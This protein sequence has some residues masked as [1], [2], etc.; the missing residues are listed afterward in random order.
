MKVTSPGIVDGV[1]DDAYGIKGETNAFGMPVVSLPLVIEEAPEGTKSF[2][3]FLEDKDAFPVT[4]GFSWIH[5]VAANIVDPVLEEDASRKHPNFVQ[6]VN[7]WISSHGG[8]QDPAHCACYGG[9]APPDAPHIYELHVYALDTLLPLRNGFYPNQ[10]YRLMHGHVLEE[11]VV[12]GRY[13]P[14]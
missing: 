2:A 14:A 10:L 8:N 11:V 9:M 5:W 1:I 4:G 6:G 12:Y 7:S 13:S 3:I